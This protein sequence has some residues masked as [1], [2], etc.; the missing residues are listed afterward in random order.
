M[1][2]SHDLVKLQSRLCYC[3]DSFLLCRKSITDRSHMSYSA[4]VLMHG[5]HKDILDGGTCISK[6]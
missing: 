1:K 2:I 3:F 6:L 4:R 5:G